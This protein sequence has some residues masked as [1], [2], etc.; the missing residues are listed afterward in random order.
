M[1]REAADA[2]VRRGAEMLER[3][4]VEDAGA[5]V[6]EALAAASDKAGAHFLLAR[7]MRRMGRREEAVSHY[8]ATLETTP[9][10][11]HAGRATASL[12]L[13]H[14]LLDLGC[15]GEAWPVFEQAAASGLATS[16]T[17][18]VVRA[19]LGLASVQSTLGDA[20]LHW[21]H[22]RQA[23]RLSADIDDDALRV[24]AQNAL[25]VELDAWGSLE[26]AQLAV[27]LLARCMQSAD[28][29]HDKREI[30]RTAINVTS[31]LC[32]LGRLEEALDMVRF[33]EEVA[34]DL[35]A[36]E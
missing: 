24:S 9:T 26:G 31:P 12:E 10:G 32:T 4:D 16:R 25:A 22:L 14:T 34:P 2:A 30:I 20:K 23:Y 36:E 18:T 33:L 6:A 21:H 27:D 15:Y 17:A 7:S 35:E 28:E 29:R 11:N 8:Q 3:G 13:G 5:L 1:D 19:H